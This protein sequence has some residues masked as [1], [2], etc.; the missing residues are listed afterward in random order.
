MPDFD[1]LQYSD[2][3]KNMIRKMLEFKPADRPSASEVKTFVSEQ[4]PKTSFNVSNISQQSK[5]I[6][7]TAGGTLLIY[8]YRNP[9]KILIFL[10]IKMCFYL[11]GTCYANIIF[12]MHRFVR[13]RSKLLRCNHINLSHRVDMNLIGF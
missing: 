5:K 1:R 7:F 4:K 11:S 13:T 12:Q 10:N 6:M 9:E 3:I 2:P 8:I